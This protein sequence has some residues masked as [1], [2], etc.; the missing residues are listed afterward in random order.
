MP[1]KL[2]DEKRVKLI[3]AAIE[4]FKEK[5]PGDTTV[6]DITKQAGASSATFYRYFKNKDDIYTVIVT[7]FLVDFTAAWGGSTD[8]SPLTGLGEEEALDAVA[9]TLRR[10]FEFYVQHKEVA[11]AI[12]RRI[13]PIDDRF[14]ERGQ[15]MLEMFLQ[16]VERFLGVLGSAGLG[17]DLEPRLG[18]AVTVGAV[19]GAAVEYIIHGEEVDVENMVGQFMSVVR[20]GIVPKTTGQRVQEA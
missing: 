7:G 11:G 2:S 10:V 19:F 15:E 14:V 13:V 5:G 1:R 9:E 6:R 20:H 18:A 16:E 3:N 12:F 17:K 4:V 8:F